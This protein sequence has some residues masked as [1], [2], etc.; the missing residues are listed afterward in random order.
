[1]NQLPALSRTGSLPQDFACLLSHILLLALVLACGAPL[2][3]E[4]QHQAPDTLP[5]AKFVEAR[6]QNSWLEQHFFQL[7]QYQ[8]AYQTQLSTYTQK[9]GRFGNWELYYLSQA[10]GIGGLLRP[11]DTMPA[12]EVGLLYFYNAQY[13]VGRIMLADYT[14][15]AQSFTRSMT[16]ERINDSLLIFSEKMQL[17]NQEKEVLATFTWEIKGGLETSQRQYPLLPAR[18]AEAEQ[19][20]WQA[21]KKGEAEPLPATYAVR[22]RT[23][24]R[25]PPID[26]LTYL[27]VG[28]TALEEAY[29]G[30]LLRDRTF[31]QFHYYEKKLPKL[32]VYECYQL[33]YQP[34]VDSSFQTS[35]PYIGFDALLLYHRETKAARL[36]I[37]YFSYYIDA[38]NELNTWIDRNRGMIRLT[39]TM[40]TDDDPDEN[41]DY[42]AIEEEGPVHTLHISD[43]G[44][45]SIRLGTQ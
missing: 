12:V 7:S 25:L 29:L 34:F 21:S 11:Y 40:V 13:Q 27:Y 15:E 28:G 30:M 31:Q 8:A 17:P 9:L 37:S 6:Y 38:T 26:Q 44:T 32:S 23:F 35:D 19:H 16:Y 33:R 41:G 39:E 5:H 14:F 18:F 43:Y 10:D 24:Y 3:G 36:L 42:G 45:I 4:A 22:E 2:A 20:Y 1:M